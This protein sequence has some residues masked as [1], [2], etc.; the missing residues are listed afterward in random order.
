MA[1]IRLVNS[2]EKY[3]F[4]LATLALL[5]IIIPA[6]AVELRPL[7]DCTVKVFREI[8]RTSAWSGKRP[9]GCLADIHVEKRPAGIFV[10]V[11]NSGTSEQG[12]VRVSLS[13]AMGFYEVADRKAL[14]KG[15]HDITARAARI[16][17]CLNS[18]IEVNDPLEC[19]DYGIKSYLAGEELGVE[20]KRQIW[21]DDG[22][23][24]SVAEYA[25]GDTQATVTPPADLFGGSAL[26]PGTKLNIDILETE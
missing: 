20:Y 3:L 12:W 8:N 21:L 6:E 4:W 24:H 2:F 5:F 10:T 14:A 15:S 16:E 19:R 18:I 1:N 11:W 23:R 22:G 7:A 26:P 17:R 25:Y 13:S 9:K